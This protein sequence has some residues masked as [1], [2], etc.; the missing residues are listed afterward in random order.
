MGLMTQRPFDRVGHLLKRR[1]MG[2][3]RQGV[4]KGGTFFGGQIQLSRG[5]IGHIYGDDPS[6][7]FPKRLNCD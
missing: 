3:V 6:N 5:T 4:E 2:R 7:F 1:W